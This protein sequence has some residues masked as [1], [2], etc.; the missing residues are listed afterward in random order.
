[1]SN[2]QPPVGRFGGLSLIFEEGFMKKHWWIIVLL[3][4]LVMFFGGC[5]NA[6]NNDD[7]GKE[8]PDDMRGVAVD[9][10]EA[11]WVAPGA[12]NNGSKRKYADK[13]VP[14]IGED[15]NASYVHIYFQPFKDLLGSQTL[16]N[17][18]AFEIT[19]KLR[20]V[21][22]WESPINMMWQCAFDPYGTWARSSQS[23]DYIDLV[24]PG[25]D[26]EFTCI[27]N[28]R[29]S[30][31]NWDETKSGNGKTK[32]T[33]PEMIGLA[34]QIEMDYKFEAGYIEVLDFSYKNAGP[35]PNIDGPKAPVAK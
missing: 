15:D 16:Q 20:F 30:G 10:T 25:V 13:K 33:L 2:E 23:G 34:I 17:M 7:D 19:V 24:Y 11:W 18:N 3:A 29:F 9:G 31:G 4:A 6:K 28:E 21:S 22:E 8:E 1:M 32:V 27:P 5:G 35:G 26:R 14:V 12:K